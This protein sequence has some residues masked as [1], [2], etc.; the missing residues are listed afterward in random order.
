MGCVN[1]CICTGNCLFC[2]SY[3]K[4]EYVGQSEDLYDYLHGRDS[5]ID[6]E[7]QRRQEEAYYQEM[8]NRHEQEMQQMFD[9]LAE[10]GGEK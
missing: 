1:A 2:G 7:E 5:E 10:E 8:Y 9:A 6:R 4:E 3:K